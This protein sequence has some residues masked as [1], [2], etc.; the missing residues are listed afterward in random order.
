MN[1]SFSVLQNPGNLE[2]LQKE[3]SSRKCSLFFTESP[4]NPFLRC[5]NIPKAA[6]LCR[7][8]DTVFCVDST[9]ATPINQ[10][11]LELGADLVLHS[12]TKYLAGH[13]DVLAGTIAGKQEYVAKIR[14]L[15][16]ILGGLL[17]PHAAYLII[18][19]LKTLQLRVERQNQTG[20]ALAKA[21]ESHSLI[22]RVH[23]PGLSSHPDN[24]FAKD[25]MS[26]YG[27]VVSFEIKGDLH[28]T[29]RFIDLLKIPFI[30]PSLGGVESLVEQPT[31]I[32]YWD[33]TPEQRA[34][35]GIK[36]NLVRF[37]CGV[38][39]T[40]DIIEDVLSSINA[41]RDNYHIWKSEPYLEF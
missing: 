22:N 36:E 41:L 16:K 28:M 18:R 40:E 30:A 34:E 29:S 26:G 38:E 9:F 3:L 12:A 14:N 7:K 13:N 21:L 25:F 1:I 15:H 8:F 11:P 2:E 20:M 6:E 17:D 37:S 5:V 10:R 24:A 33:Q 39:D 35:I 27:G 23:Y 19:G 32:S 4:T 31:I